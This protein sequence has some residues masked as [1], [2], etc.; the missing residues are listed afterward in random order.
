MINI[1]GLG[2]ITWDRKTSLA[3]VYPLWGADLYG[4]VEPAF[5][6]KRMQWLFE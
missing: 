4:E 3:M 2:G 6:L 5:G 1:G